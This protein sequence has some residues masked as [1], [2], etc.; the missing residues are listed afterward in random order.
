M[1]ERGVKHT[2]EAT[3]AKPKKGAYGGQRSVDIFELTEQY[4][5]LLLHQLA[6]IT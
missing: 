6:V 2:A 4:N 5:I 1:L 3:P